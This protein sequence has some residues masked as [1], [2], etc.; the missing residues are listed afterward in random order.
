[1]STGK[2]KAMQQRK[3]PGVKAPSARITVV[4]DQPV[5]RA[6]GDVSAQTTGLVIFS[7]FFL[8]EGTVSRAVVHVGELKVPEGDTVE[9]DIYADGKKQGS[10]VL[11]EG[12]NQLP[13]FEGSVIPRLTTMSFVVRKGHHEDV[14]ADG[15]P[16]KCVGVGFLFRRSE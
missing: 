13:L 8:E 16:L 11:H 10:V 9:L 15:I 5:T 4:P 1:M 2:T 14:L 3:K 6:C 7:H 12:E